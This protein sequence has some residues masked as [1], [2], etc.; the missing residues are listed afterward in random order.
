M[1]VSEKKNS[2]EYLAAREKRSTALLARATSAYKLR[3]SCA[4]VRGTQADTRKL[5]LPTPA[6][7]VWYRR[8][9]SRRTRPPAFRTLFC[10]RWRNLCRMSGARTSDQLLHH[11]ITSLLRNSRCALLY[12][13]NFGIFPCAE[14]VNFTRSDRSAAVLSSSRPLS[15]SFSPRWMRRQRTSSVARTPSPI[16][17][18]SV[19][20][21]N[22]VGHHVLHLFTDHSP[23]SILSW[24][25]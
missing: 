2:N 6:I 5:A 21:E 7:A 8:L 13:M 3:H 24:R 25:L 16:L 9:I 17:S 19:A 11:G 22:G 18:S 12:C 15:A 14:R 10:G 23:R 4:I 1:G 20:A